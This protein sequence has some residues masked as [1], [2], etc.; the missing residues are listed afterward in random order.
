MNKLKNNIDKNR[1][2]LLERKILAR[3]RENT[4]H[5]FGKLSR[6]EA[7][8]LCSC[9]LPLTKQETEVILHRLERYGLLE[10]TSQ[11]VV[12]RR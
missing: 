4:Q 7:N 10:I 1:L 2:S 8:R 3:L 12:I 6:S 9:A 11:N 5:S